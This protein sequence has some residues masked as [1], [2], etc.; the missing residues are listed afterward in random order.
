MHHNKNIV[1]KPP[2]LHQTT[3]VTF[4]DGVKLELNRRER[5]HL[6]IFGDKVTRKY[7][8]DPKVEI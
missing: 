2:I 4:G 7:T 1:K 5:R 6:G 3:I 8:F